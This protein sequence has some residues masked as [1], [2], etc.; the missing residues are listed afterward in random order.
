MMTARQLALFA[1]KKVGAT[2]LLNHMINHKE[3]CKT[4]N[5]VGKLYQKIT[6]LA[7]RNLCC[8][9]QKINA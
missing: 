4:L 5:G 6:F 7:P 3:T 9:H 2:T 1:K 8:K